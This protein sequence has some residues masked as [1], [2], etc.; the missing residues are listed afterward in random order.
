MIS[1]DEEEKEIKKKREIIE[2]IVL[3]YEREY[4]SIH[5]RLDSENFSMEFDQ[6]TKFIK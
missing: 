4:L 1:D 5:L 2:K 3:D 6:Y